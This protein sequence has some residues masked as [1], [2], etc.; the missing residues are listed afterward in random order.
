MSM[1]F[2]FPTAYTT[3]AGR[4]LNQN[5]ML[6]K[7]SFTKHSLTLKKVLITR[8]IRWTASQTRQ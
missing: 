1:L 7:E 8:N 6:G 3:Q 2:D 4:I 5:Q